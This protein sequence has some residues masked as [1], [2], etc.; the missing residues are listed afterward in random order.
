[1]PRHRREVVVLAMPVEDEHAAVL[2]FLAD[3]VHV[4]DARKRSVLP[5]DFGG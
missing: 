3:A 4:V 1:M 2:A 5:D